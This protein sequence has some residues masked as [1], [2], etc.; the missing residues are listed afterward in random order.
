MSESKVSGLRRCGLLL[1]LLG[2]ILALAVRPVLAQGGERILS[3][4]TTL[5]V[6]LSPD[7]P[8]VSY[9]FDAAANSLAT[10]SL[11]NVSGGALSLQISDINGITLASRSD[12]EADGS[13]RVSDLGLFSGGRYFVFIYFAPGSNVVDTKFDL[14]F[15]L[16]AG[17]Q[18][19]LDDERAEPGAEEPQLIL[20]EAGIDVRLTWRGGADLNLEVRSPTGQNLHWDS[21][22]TE[23]GGVFGFDSNGLCQVISPN[24][25]ETATWQP[26]FLPTG[27]YEVIVYY[28]QV[29]DTLTGSVPF[30]VEVTVDGLFRGGIAD[31]LSPGA[32]GQENVYVARFE[33]GKDGMTTI[34][35]GGEIR[36]SSITVAPSGFD[37]ATD[38]ATPI[39]R[40]VAVVGAISNEQPFVTYSFAGVADELISVDMQALRPPL[41]TLLQLV[42]PTGKVVNV[43]DDAG[44]ATLNSFIANARLLSTGVPTPLLRRDMPRNLAARKGDSG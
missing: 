41:D 44:F 14:R 33:I 36:P 23:D 16:A 6:D 22:F 26:G 42:D 3:A 2:A 38:V 34:N 13:V 17:D 35:A 8:G 20:L 5:S 24:P 43:N 10:I 1:V 32:Q 18:P 25:E 9:V 40:D 7:T 19:D 21:R 31:V 27:S 28:E 15:D 12:A 4:G 30:N 39:V 29:C 37:S 11:E